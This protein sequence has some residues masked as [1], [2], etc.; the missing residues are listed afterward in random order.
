MFVDWLSLA[1]PEAHFST[2]PA[3]Q[4]R[5]LPHPKEFDCYLLTG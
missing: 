3:P 4:R 1:L 5:A 2:V